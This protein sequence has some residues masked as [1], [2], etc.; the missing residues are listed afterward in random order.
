MTVSATDPDG[1]VGMLTY[2]FDLDNDGTFDLTTTASEVSHIFDDQGEYVVAVRVRNADGLE[3]VG[4]VVVEVS[5]APPRLSEAD[6]VL[7]PDGGGGLLVSVRDPGEFDQLT[8]EVDFDDGRQ[9]SW[10][11]EHG[12]V[13]L[14][15]AIPD[16]L[17]PG[18]HSVTL[19]LHDEEGGFDSTVLV[20]SI[21]SSGQPLTAAQTVSAIVTTSP[22]PSALPVENSAFLLNA[23]LVVVGRPVPVSVPG[24]Q[25][26]TALA[27]S[28]AAVGSA[29][30]TQSI[31]TASGGGGGQ[32]ESQA[33]D[34]GAPPVNP[35]AAPFREAVRVL[36]SMADLLLSLAA[37]AERLVAAL[38]QALAD[39]RAA[40][41]AGVTTRPRSCAADVPA[42]SPPES[43]APAEPSRTG[44]F[45]TVVLL[46]SALLVQRAWAN[47]RM[48]AANLMKNRR[49]SNLPRPHPAP[50]PDRGLRHDHTSAKTRSGR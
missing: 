39:L 49:T 35:A 37:P 6:V 33:A 1:P 26:Q 17:A 25:S 28:P 9:R 38:G 18:T 12:A 48:S 32:V 46:L 40:A 47:S 4:S 15:G 43:E 23:L 36:Q 21:P 19:T 41:G 2:E 10:S 14:R 29:A 20:F 42:P 7:E 16:D 5:N 11:L 44:A 22:T 24:P 31:R 50:R 13:T 27:A 3:A 45:Q 8:L 34:E 30:V